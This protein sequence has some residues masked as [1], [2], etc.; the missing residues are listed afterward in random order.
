MLKDAEH[1]ICLLR[2]EIE[3]SPTFYRKKRELRTS[4]CMSDECK[5]M[6]CEILSTTSYKCHCNQMGILGSGCD[7]VSVNAD[8]CSSSP[9]W[10]NSECIN[11]NDNTSFECKCKNGRAGYNCIGHSV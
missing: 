9:C 1:A 10:G 2:N 6:E 8:P 3:I 4:V 7:L 5:K 11:S